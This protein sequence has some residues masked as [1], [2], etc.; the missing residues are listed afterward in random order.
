MQCAIG[1]LIEEARGPQAADGGVDIAQHGRSKSVHGGH[2]A[3]LEEPVLLTVDI[4]EFFR[5][6]R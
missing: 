1:Q 5:D 6:L 3:A 4:R 2:F